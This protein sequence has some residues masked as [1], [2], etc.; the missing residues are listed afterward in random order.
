M[1]DDET[2]RVHYTYKCNKR[3]KQELEAL[4]S[5]GRFTSSVALIGTSIALLRWCMKMA[6]EGLKVGAWNEERDRYIEV[7][8][9]CIESAKDSTKRIQ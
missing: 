8:L 5:I 9:P 4:K 7:Y 1:A 6:Q 3:D 2:V